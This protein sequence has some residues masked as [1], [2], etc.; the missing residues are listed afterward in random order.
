MH[1]KFLNIG[2]LECFCWNCDSSF[3]CSGITELIKV[4]HLK[5]VTVTKIR[6]Y[7]DVIDLRLHN[8]Y[9]ESLSKLCNPFY[10]IKFTIQEEEFHSATSK[11][12]GII[13]VE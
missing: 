6:N 11:S 13:L 2:L 5:V 10:F 4:V 12:A 1:F 7:P 9:A 8:I 3:T